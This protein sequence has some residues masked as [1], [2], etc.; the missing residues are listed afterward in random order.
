MEKTCPHCGHTKPLT[1]EFWLPRKESKDGFRG[2]CRE[3][4]YAQQR[5]NKRRHYANHAERIKQERR[6]EHQANPEKRKLRDL[7]YYLENKNKKLQYNHEYHKRNRDRLIPAASERR[8]RKQSL[9]YGW[10]KA[11]P[12]DR[13]EL[14]LWKD[15]TYAEVCRQ[16]AIEFFDLLEKRLSP[17]ERTALD[18]LMDADFDH[19]TAD[20][21]MSMSV[22]DFTDT[23]TI[24]RSVA[25]KVRSTEW[26][27]GF[28]TW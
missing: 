19:T 21:M 1:I 4:W 9:D 15:R 10:S 23:L 11:L 14:K 12:H 25:V 7:R 8:R 5:P 26:T 6:E 17:V 16:E 28:W 24:I 22:N 18:C 3:C 2:T 13:K 27:P 20:E